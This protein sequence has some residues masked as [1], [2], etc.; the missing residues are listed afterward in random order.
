MKG[1]YVYKLAPSHPN[2][3]LDYVFGGGR[4]DM[5]SKEIEMLDAVIDGEN[6]EEHKDFLKEVEVMFATWGMVNFTEEQIKNY[7]PNLKVLYYAAGSVQAFVRPFLACN[8]QVISAWQAMSIPVAEFSVAAILMLNKGLFLSMQDYYQNKKDFIESKNRCQNLF[9]GTYETK[10]GILGAGAIGADTI[11][12][13]K[14]YNVEV[15]VYGRNLEKIKALNIGVE[16]IY[17]MEEIFSE[18]QVI[19][20]HIADNERTKGILN[21]D[22]FKLMKPTAAFLNT[23]R[24]AQVVEADLA[25]ALK[26]E[27]NRFAFLDVTWPEPMEADCPLW[28]LP[29]CMVFPHLAGYATQEV[30][31]LSDC[32]IEQMR[33]YVKGEKMD[34][35]VTEDMLEGMA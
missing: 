8:V 3:R 34:Y 5:I 9:P 12:L 32:V 19:S 29:N 17:T 26:E 31:R 14:S 1:C 2:H 27:P 16:K 22:L 25:R 15:M 13:L 18:C 6:M 4:K 23:G 20:N 28:D 24:G 21:Y 35:V 10:V 11:R 7:F 33:K 30:F